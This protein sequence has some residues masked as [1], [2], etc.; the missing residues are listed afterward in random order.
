MSKALSEAARSGNYQLVRTLVT[1]PAELVADKN[2]ALYSELK[3]V[4]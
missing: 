1:Q 4:I 3:M 2:S